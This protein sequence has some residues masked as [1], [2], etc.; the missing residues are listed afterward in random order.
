VA[1]E[2]RAE[3]VNF[4]A[5]FPLHVTWRLRAEVGSIRRYRTAALARRA[6]AAAH[7]PGFRVL[8]FSLLSNH[9]HCLVEAE[10]ALGLAR[11]MQGLAIRLARG[12]NRVLDRCGTVFAERYHARVLRSPREVRNV[13]AFILRNDSHCTSLD[14]RW[15][16][17]TVMP[18]SRSVLWVLFDRLL[19]RGRRGLEQ[20]VGDLSAGRAPPGSIDLEFCDCLRVPEHAHA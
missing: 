10:T 9:M 2:R 6:I 18:H 16:G 17:A 14:R 8:E 12:W 15:R 20:A 11:G 13:L 7:K 1:H 5:R 4:K 3:L 19:R